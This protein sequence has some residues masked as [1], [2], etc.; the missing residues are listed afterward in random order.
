MEEK[1]K[2]EIVEIEEEES[3]YKKILI[4]VTG[5]FLVLLVLSFIFVN[6]PIV[7][8]IEGFFESKPVQG[9]VISLD[10]FSISL[11]NGTY[12]ILNDT[13]FKNQKNEISACLLG[14]KEGNVYH[15]TSLYRPE[16]YSQTF[17]S[18]SFKECSN[19]TL[20]ILHTHP[21]KQCIASEADIVLLN[22]TKNLNPDV[23]MVVMC[24]SGRF[25]VY[26]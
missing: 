6:F 9:N 1:T 2:E 7:D 10:N 4:I 18:V 23:L 24:E 8:V 25:S 13:Y 21:Y 12:G 26:S 17:S 20:I 14:Y 11:E 15:I 3:I 19:E 16:I 22:K 5:V